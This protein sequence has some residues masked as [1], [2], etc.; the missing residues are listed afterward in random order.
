MSELALCILIALS[1][2][3]GAV[4]G[5]IVYIIMEAE[6]ADRKN[7]AALHRKNS[8]HRGR[9]ARGGEVLDQWGSGVIL[10]MEAKG[11]LASDRYP[12]FNR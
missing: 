6:N 12:R 10:P 5:I 8:G 7:R 4:I 11:Q 1:A 9:E 2:M 3:G